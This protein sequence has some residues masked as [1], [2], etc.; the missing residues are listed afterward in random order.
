MKNKVY[1]RYTEPRWK[2]YIVTTNEA[3]FTPEECKIISDLGRTMPRQDGVIGPGKQGMLDTNTRLSHISWIPFDNPRAHFMYQTIDQWL[4]KININHFGFD[5]VHLNEFAQYTEYDENGHYDWHMD[6]DTNMAA[7]PPARKISMSLLLSNE[8]EY[9]GGGLEFIKPGN[10][11]N[12]KQGHAVFFAS[13]VN[14]KVQKVTKGNRK[15]L[16][17]WFGGP[18]FR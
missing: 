8:N 16:V 18:S 10:V 3:L 14:H 13:F 15:S 7:E 12:I 11:I 4:Q 2:S 1:V 5:G 9:E 6:C 17:M